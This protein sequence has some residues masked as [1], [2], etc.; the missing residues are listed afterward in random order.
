MANP[1]KVRCEDCRNCLWEESYDPETGDESVWRV[2]DAGVVDFADDEID[3]DK[4]C[5][6]FESL[7]NA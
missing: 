7:G 3:L 4:E 5:E 2:C 1:K 6:H